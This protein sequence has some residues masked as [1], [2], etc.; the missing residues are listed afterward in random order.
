MNNKKYLIRMDLNYYLEEIKENCE[1]AYEYVIKNK[2]DKE[3]I[4][5]GLKDAIENVEVIEKLI[6]ILESEYENEQL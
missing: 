3:T 2:Y 5:Y 6:N 1:Q 4:K